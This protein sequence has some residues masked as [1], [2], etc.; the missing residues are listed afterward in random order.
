MNKSRVMCID[1]YLK[2]DMYS[3]FIIILSDSLVSQLMLNQ[4]Y[5]AAITQNRRLERVPLFL[6][7]ISHLFL[8]SQFKIGPITLLPSMES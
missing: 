6:F 1:R 4:Q 5:Y 8:Q 2:R 7:R 3:K